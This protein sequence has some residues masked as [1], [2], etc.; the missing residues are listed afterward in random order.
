MGQRLFF[1]L[2]M[3]SLPQLEEGILFRRLNFE[4]V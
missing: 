1:S 2:I 3:L 4:S